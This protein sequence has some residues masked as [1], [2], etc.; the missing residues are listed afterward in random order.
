MPEC[1]TSSSQKNGGSLFPERL[2]CA[3]FLW[4]DTCKLELFDEWLGIGMQSG[5]GADS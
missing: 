2:C 4:D 5:E 1:K 3:R